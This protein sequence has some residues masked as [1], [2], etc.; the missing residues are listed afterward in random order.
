MEEKRTTAVRNFGNPFSFRG[1]SGRGDFLLYGILA[2]YA[3]LAA[4]VYLTMQ[5]ENPI[6]FYV[7]LLV[8]LVVG[9]AAT[10]RRTRDR[11]ESVFFVLLL[12]MF[13]YIN[14]IVMFYLLLAPGR[15][16]AGLVTSE[17]DKEVSMEASG[18]P[19]V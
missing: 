12:S 3:L 10:V 6:F 9:L 17:A 4:G 1:R 8:G 15:E 7:S 19:Q 18:D 2:T 5:T 11:E 16:T 14:I 13:P